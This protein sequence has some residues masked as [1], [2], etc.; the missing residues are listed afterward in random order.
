MK[1][2]VRFGLV[3]SFNFLV[4]M[5]ILNSLSF[6][7]GFNKGFF[8]AL[9]SVISFTVANVSSYQMNKRWTFKNNSENSRYKIFLI[10]SMVGVFI[11]AVVVYNL[12]S[13]INQPYFS[14][15]TWMNV[16][17]VIATLFV[18]FFN[19]F[20]YKKYVFRN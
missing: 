20:S 17:K 15:T 1:R 13:H 8:A 14:D 6:V 2:F 7:T 10:V 12:T 19:Y 4:D 18:V 9:F 3:G 16:S 5:I 11:N